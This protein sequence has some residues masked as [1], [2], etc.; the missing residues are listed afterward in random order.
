[1]HP[2]SC[3]EVRQEYNGRRVVRCRE[4]PGWLIIKVV[5]PEDYIWELEPKRTDIRS[6]VVNIPRVNI[7]ALIDQ[8]TAPYFLVIICCVKCWPTRAVGSIVVEV[9]PWLL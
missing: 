2:F 4:T 7:Q 6:L 3:Q 9:L 5:D 8:E 1:V